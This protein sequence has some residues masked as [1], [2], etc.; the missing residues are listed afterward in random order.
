MGK[1]FLAESP[2]R[3]LIGGL[4]YLLAVIALATLAYV[5]A[6][7]SF[8]DAFY[9]VIISVFTVGYGELHPIQGVLRGITISTI[10][11]G[12]LGITFLAA[13]FVQ[14]ITITQLQQLFG[15]KRMKTQI[16]KLN[17]HVIVCG[18]GRIGQMLADEL[19]AGGAEFVII[20]LDEE[21]LAEAVTHGH[22]VW[23]GDATDEEVLKT[24]GVERARALATVVPNDA[25]NVFITLSARNISKELEI[26][27]RANAT[28][29]K[30][31]L[32]QAGASSVV[33][34]THIGAERIAQLILFPRTSIITDGTTRMRMLS[35]GLHTLGLDI[36]IMAVAA[37]S[38][39]AGA[40][41]DAIER[42]AVGSLF[43]IA[44]TRK[45]GET[46]TRPDPTTL[47][48][49]GDGVVVITRSG[50]SRP[51]IS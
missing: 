3:N 28:S 23:R 50:R 22:M 20:D 1:T 46:I 31:K 37:D 9:F 14:F 35:A 19:S 27:A 40:S 34:P 33:E 8:G 48:E 45:N 11:M 2:W 21:R 25:V 39:L 5:L 51:K 38:P 44:V 16:D 41:I 18:Y 7:W 49:A 29:T 6:G 10:V 32:L 24:V 30:S 12:W 13:A 4:I 17:G 36:E 26:I 42:E 47:I 15:I 43:V